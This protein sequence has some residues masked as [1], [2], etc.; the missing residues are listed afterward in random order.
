MAIQIRRGSS[1]SWG[2]NKS[3]IVAG[4]PVIATDTKRLFVGTGSGTY[5]EFMDTDA[6]GNEIDGAISDNNTVI[7]G[8]I[9]DAI[10]ANNFN[11][12]LADT[13]IEEGTSGIWKY[14][15]WHSGIA[16]CWSH[17]ATV[18]HN[19]STA[20]GSGYYTVISGTPYPTGLFIEAPTIICQPFASQGLLFA[21]VYGNSET[22]FSI[23]LGGLRS[24]TLDVGFD[25]YAIGKW[26]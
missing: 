25:N 23:F 24:E 2:S 17:T 4:E 18:S 1:G 11:E 7:D 8:R 21:T 13:V 6:V 26:K 9:S 15:K 20:Y 12:P 16:E 19:I 5:A 3:N 10:G 14:R 22:A